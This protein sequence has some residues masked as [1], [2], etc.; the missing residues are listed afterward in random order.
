ME[1]NMKKIKY[2]FFSSILFFITL[3]NVNAE[4]ELNSLKININID[5]TGTMHVVETWNMNNDSNTEIYKQEYNLGNM[6]ITNFKVRDESK[7][8]T[9][10]D[11]WDIY[12]NFESK[13]YKYGINEVSEGIEL[14]WGISE[15]KSKI[16][17]I[18]Y[19][20][21]NAVF[22]TN[23]SQILYK[24]LINT[25]DFST[26]SVSVVISGPE[27]F[28]DTLD[29]WGY[30]YKGYAYVKDGKIYMSNEENT[31]FSGSDYMV[32]LV[33]FPLKMFEVNEDNFYSQYE[34]FNDVYESAEEGSYEYDYDNDYNNSFDFI[35]ILINF[36]IFAMAFA[37]PVIYMIKSNKYKFGEAGGN[38]NTKTINYFRDIPC[39]KDVFRAQFISIAYKLNNNSNKNNFLGTLFLK[40]LFE[41]KVSI[42]KLHKNG[43]FKDKEETCIQL[44]DNIQIDNPVENEIY[45]V[46]KT[47]SKDN[48][49][50]KNELSK[51][52]NANYSKMFKLIDKCEEYGR[53]LY[54][55]DSLVTKE[56]SKYLI[57]DKVKNDAIELAGLKKYLKDF[58]NINQKE[59]IEVKLW[60]EYLMFAQI[61]GMADKVA[62]QFKNLYPE[63][64]AEVNNY[65]LNMTD[66][67]FLNSMSR[68]AASSASSA[69]SAAQSYSGGGGGFSSGGGGGGSFG[70]GH[71]GSR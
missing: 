12:G 58:S 11:N 28:K 55:A 69:R 24:E 20:V 51:W 67:I 8:Y 19:D 4:N 3:I 61:F 62:E 10:K 2:I 9:F 39:K 42:I 70:G 60:K 26:S 15:Y 46:I 18:S 48:V 36:F 41:D 40:W 38:I 1:V 33:K 34:N 22:N 65:H 63:I 53:D 54:V 27:E 68:V 13:K 44:K 66:I 17:T 25:S 56:N 5:K 52:A 45:S 35:S 6:S 7:E 23:D 37:A 43:F 14:C 71:S 64:M 32:L 31:T 30:G 49:L 21:V 57:N 59:A 29:V 47:A 50:E 16:Y